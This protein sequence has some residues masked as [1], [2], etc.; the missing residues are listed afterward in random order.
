M[1]NQLH[2]SNQVCRHGILSLPSLRGGTYCILTADLP[3][4]TT[5]SKSALK[6]VR[7]QPQNKQSKLFVNEESAQEAMAKFT[8][9]RVRR[10]QEDDAK[11]A[12]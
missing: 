4:P 6:L 11:R 5:C 8:V 1:A 7:N 12:D 10:T 9:E 2:S 3:R